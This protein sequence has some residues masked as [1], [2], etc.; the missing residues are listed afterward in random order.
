MLNNLT[1]W[2][3]LII[4]GVLAAMAV[5]VAVIVLLIIRAARGRRSGDPAERLAQLDQLRAQGLLSDAE[6]ATKRQEIIGRL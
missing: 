1:G 5:V 2:H 4:L 6:Y 3:A